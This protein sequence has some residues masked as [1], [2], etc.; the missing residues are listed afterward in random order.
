[1]AR[2]LR[3]RTLV[4]RHLRREGTDV[5]RIL[6]HALRERV[7]PWKFRRQ[8]PIGRRIA[9]FA[10]PA[11]KLAIELDGSQHAERTDAD[12]RR[13]AELASHGYRV[14]RFW[15]NEILDNLDGVLETVRRAL[16]A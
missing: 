11:R 13:S 9:D 5:E 16:E 10:C 14:I 2:P 4:A 12:D 3:G 7:G 1:M 8:H 6:W 15:N